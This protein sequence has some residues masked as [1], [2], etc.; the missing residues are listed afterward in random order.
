MPSMLC[1]ELVILLPLFR[2]VRMEIQR[3]QPTGVIRT[4]RAQQNETLRNNSFSK[5][6]QSCKLKLYL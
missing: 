1:L 6:I 2:E 4:G 3:L 5:I